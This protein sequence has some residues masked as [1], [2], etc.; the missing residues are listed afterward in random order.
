MF[1]DPPP[2]KNRRFTPA[3]LETEIMLASWMKR[4]VRTYVNDTPFYPWLPITPIVPFPNFDLNF[5]E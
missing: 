3:E 1:G 4:P 2:Q 5:K